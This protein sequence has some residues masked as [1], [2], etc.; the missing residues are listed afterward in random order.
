M[1]VV[2]QALMMIASGALIIANVRIGGLILSTT[3]LSVIATRDNPLLAL[4]DYMWRHNLMNMLKDVAVAGIGILI[5]NR[6][7]TIRHRKPQ[8][9]EEVRYEAV[10]RQ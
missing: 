8:V 5:F 9:N 4:S 7:L 1:L 6:R 2:A 10:G 3:M